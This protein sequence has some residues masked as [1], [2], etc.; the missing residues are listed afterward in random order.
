MCCDPYWWLFCT[1]H[2]SRVSY[3][4]KRIFII[5]HL[6]KLQAKLQRDFFAPTV[7]NC[8]VFVPQCTRRHKI[9]FLPMEPRSG[10]IAIAITRCNSLTYRRLHVVEWVECSAIYT[11]RVLST[12][13]NARRFSHW[14]LQT[15]SLY[16]L[17]AYL[18]KTRVVSCRTCTSFS[19]TL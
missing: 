7:A 11:R 15:R 18:T 5:G 6:T 2:L 14:L 12:F 9:W 19:A 4:G 8:P 10:P 17:L 1:D 3:V 13:S 16:Q